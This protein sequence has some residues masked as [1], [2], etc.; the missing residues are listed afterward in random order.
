MKK[1]RLVSGEEFQ[2]LARTN[3]EKCVVTK[4]DAMNWWKE[5]NQMHKK[6]NQP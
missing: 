3:P 5:F 4:E 2:Q 6:I 1:L